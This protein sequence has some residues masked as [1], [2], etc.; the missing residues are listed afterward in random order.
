MRCVWNFKRHLCLSMG[1]SC[2]K[3]KRKKK[4]YKKKKKKRQIALKCYKREIFDEKPTKRKKWFHIKISV[5]KKKNKTG[6]R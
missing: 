4:R 1:D 2:K 3:E 5:Y 6:N